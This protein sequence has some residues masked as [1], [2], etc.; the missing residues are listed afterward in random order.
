MWRCRLQGPGMLRC[1]SRGSPWIRYVRRHGW[2]AREQIQLTQLCLYR[3]CLQRSVLRRSTTVLARLASRHYSI[4][5][6]GQPR[7]DWTP[8]Q[9]GPPNLGQFS[10]AGGSGRG[11]RMI[12][13]V[14]RRTYGSMWVQ[15]APRKPVPEKA[16]TWMER[17]A[18]VGPLMTPTRP[19][20]PWMQQRGRHVHDIMSK[21]R[22]GW[23]GAVPGSNPHRT[24][25]V[26][27]PT[28]RNCHPGRL[29]CWLSQ[30]AQPGPPCPPA[31]QTR[32]SHDP[33]T[34]HSGAGQFQTVR[35]RF[36]YRLL[37]STARLG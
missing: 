18:S 27:R 15:L 29:A 8:Y 16:P 17:D 28:A 12:E 31:M 30:A 6:Y 23:M 9:T 7:R 35:G 1:C 5:G 2:I 14:H 21:S 22:L 24:L 10:L 3:L 37:S 34:Q 26:N 33:C 25:P 19:C 20:S 36:I 4:S 13:M 11:G 32:N